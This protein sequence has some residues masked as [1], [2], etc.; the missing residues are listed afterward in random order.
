MRTMTTWLSAITVVVAL[1]FALAGAPLAQT[2]TTI[3]VLQF[4]VVAVDGNTLVV[5]DQAGT[6]AV[7]VPDDF[8]FDVDGKKL[9][10][11]E[12][13]PGMKGTAT[14]TTT[15]TVKP[16]TITEVKEAEV[17]RA[18]DYSVS[19]RGSDGESRR[20][21]QG[22]LDKRGVQIIKDGKS[23]R[24][25]DLKRGD[26]LTALVVTSGPPT[27]LT[28]QEVKATL[29]DSKAEPAPPTQVAAAS[30]AAQ[31]ATPAATPQPAAA[32]A[33]APTPAPAEATGMG[34]MWYVI[35]AILIALALFFFAR[36]KKEP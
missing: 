20:F 10:V 31:P 28:E 14:V 12:L 34:T 27:T 3:D 21:T 7:T 15:T 33:A 11:S 17:L 24:V 36:K 2:T 13:N 35:I 16:V 25:G 22:E 23:V 6:H 9:S 32:P 4:E 30:G 5:R 19:V 26:K 18:S 29:D 1:G 8:R